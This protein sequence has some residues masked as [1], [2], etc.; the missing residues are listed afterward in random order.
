MPWHPEV[1]PAKQV[2]LGGTQWVFVS[3]WGGG[4]WAGGI[5]RKIENDNGEVS[6]RL[7]LSHALNLP[8]ESTRHAM[9]D[10]CALCCVL[11]R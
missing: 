9:Q 3:N 10:V 2:K 7:R 8:R 4:Q 6:C 11:G 5:D 1:D